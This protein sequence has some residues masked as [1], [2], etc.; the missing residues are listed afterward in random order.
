M[1]CLFAGAQQ[2]PVAA[3]RFDGANQRQKPALHPPTRRGHAMPSKAAIEDSSE[4]NST[5]GRILPG[6][7]T[8]LCVPDH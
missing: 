5:G 1:A 8:P 2:V 4:R 6:C 7:R 3:H